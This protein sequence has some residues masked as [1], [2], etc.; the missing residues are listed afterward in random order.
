VNEI[1]PDSIRLNPDPSDPDS[2]A[3]PLRSSVQDVATPFEP[4]EPRQDELDC[5]TEGPD[6]FLDLDQA[7]EAMADCSAPCGG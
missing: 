7:G 6:G 3:V 2:G 5:T 4:F 1:D